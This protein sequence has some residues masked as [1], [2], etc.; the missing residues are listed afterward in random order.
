MAAGSSRSARRGNLYSDPDNLFVAGFIGTPEINRFA[1]K[2]EGWNVSLECG[3][4]FPMTLTHSV[5]SGTDVI[6]GFRPHHL[7]VSA[8]GPE[9][10]ITLVEPTGEGQEFAGEGRF[11]RHHDR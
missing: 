8:D 10:E 1:G 7:S 3:V 6:C 11:A 5:A 2:V 4:T 9:A